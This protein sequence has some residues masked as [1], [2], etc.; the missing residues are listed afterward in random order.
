MIDPIA[1]LVF[2]IEEL[3]RRLANVVRCGKVTEVAHDGENK[4]KVK[5]SDGKDD[6]DEDCFRSDWTTWNEKSGDK[7]ER[8]MPSVGQQVMMLSPGGLPELGWCQPGGYVKDD[9]MPEAKAGEAVYRKRDK[10]EQGNVLDVTTID[11]AGKRAVTAT[12]SHSTTV[13]DYS[14]TM[15]KDGGH[16]FKA[17]DKMTLTVTKDKGFEFAHGDNKITLDKDGWHYKGDG[18]LEHDK[19]NIGKTHKHKDVEPGSGQTGDPVEV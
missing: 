19:L 12:E 10:D 18:K 1:Q 9:D 16:V 5:F 7:S 15:T 3:E 13:G 4:G 11:G 2:K 8:S 17:G 14:H 6:K